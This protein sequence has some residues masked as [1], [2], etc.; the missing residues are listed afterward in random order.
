[1]VF[2]W[3]LIVFD[4]SESTFYSSTLEH[5]ART[6]TYQHIQQNTFP[7]KVK[8]GAKRGEHSRASTEKAAFPSTFAMGDPEFHLNSSSPC[9][10]LRLQYD[11]SSSPRATLHQNSS[12]PVSLPVSFESSAQKTI[13]PFDGQM[14]T[15]SSCRKSTDT[16]RTWLLLQYWRTLTIN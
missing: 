16:G 14:E 5:P 2:C 6:S 9:S 8:P 3:K 7:F 1:M 12:G 10:S 13:Q 11:A 4:W 15:R